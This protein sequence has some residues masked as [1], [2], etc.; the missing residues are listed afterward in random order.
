MGVMVAQ[1][2]AQQASFNPFIAE[3]LREVVHHF[4]R[5]RSATARSCK[6]VFH[7]ILRMAVTVENTCQLFG[8]LR[9][10]RV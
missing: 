4:F 9:R 1:T 8:I 10:T 5:D 7:V 3:S 2:Q 6:V